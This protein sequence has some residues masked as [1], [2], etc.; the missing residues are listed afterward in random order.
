[1]TGTHKLRLAA[2][3]L[4]VLTVLAAALGRRPAR[5]RPRA[6]APQGEEAPTPTPTRA[7]EF[8][9]RNPFGLE[10]VRV[11]EPAPDATRREE[12]AA[13][14][15]P[16]PRRAELPPV[17]L[18]LVGT[19]DAGRYAMAFFEGAGPR[20]LALEVA[21]DLG[22]VLGERFRGLVL[23]EIHRKKAVFRGPRRELV[24]E[25]DASA[26]HEGG[27]AERPPPPPPPKSSAPEGGAAADVEVVLQRSEIQA[28]LAKLPTLINQT[29]AQ[30]YFDKGV[31]A[32][33]STRASR[34]ASA[35]P[36]FAPTASRHAWGCRTA[37]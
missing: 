8:R 10:R 11:P 12:R 4:A 22:E 34:P 28:G 3:V 32:G 21:A 29:V 18:R 1:V 25:L 31:P 2:F 26:A 9:R 7:G 36:A 37:T 15:A 20:Q 30:V 13:P 23:E 17:P 19:I 5:A 27:T 33:T 16:E 35:S 24:L 14:R 6:S